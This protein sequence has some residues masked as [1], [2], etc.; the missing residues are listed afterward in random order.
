M[1]IDEEAFEVAFK[2][3]TGFT[4]KSLRV[5]TE[6]YEQAKKPMGEAFVGDGED[7][8]KL[9][10]ARD[11]ERQPS[12]ANT[13]LVQKLVDTLAHIKRDYEVSLQNSYAA[14]AIMGDSYPERLQNDINR[15][16]V[17]MQVQ[18]INKALTEA[19]AWL[20][21]QEARRE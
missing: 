4:V 3:C 7:V 13:A 1:T 16:F 12:P 2:Y 10:Q 19:T 8:A 18:R 11:G 20:E 14:E 6:A 21:Q 15:K 17:T 9:L 5:F